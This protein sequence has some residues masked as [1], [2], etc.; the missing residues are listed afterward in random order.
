MKSDVILIRII[1]KKMADRSASD[2]FSIGYPNMYEISEK[3][4]PLYLQQTQD[5]EFAT[6][7]IEAETID[8]SYQKVSAVTVGSMQVDQQF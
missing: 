4:P 8:S 6:R 5:K 7:L 3:F 1:S 2:G